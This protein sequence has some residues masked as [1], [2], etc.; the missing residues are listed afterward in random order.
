VY[1]PILV[2]VAV[3]KYQIWQFFHDRQGCGV[4]EI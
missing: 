4:H 2:A 1:I 3:C